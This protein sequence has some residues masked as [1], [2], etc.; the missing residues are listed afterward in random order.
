MKTADIVVTCVG[1]S[2]YQLR[3]DA[4]RY[5]AEII[6]VGTRVDAQGNLVGDVDFEAAKHVA[7]SLTPVPKGVGPVTVACLM[8]NVVRA[9]KLSLGVDVR[10]YQL[11]FPGRGRKTNDDVHASSSRV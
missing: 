3:T 5:G 11:G 1:S 4:I 7:G 2:N 10:G 8:E 9:A 6:D